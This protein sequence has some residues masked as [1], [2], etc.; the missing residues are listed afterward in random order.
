VLSL[1]NHPV[2]VLVVVALAA[3]LAGAT[4]EVKTS[5]KGKSHVKPRP[6]VKKAGKKAAASARAWVRTQS[7]RMARATGRGV[8]AGW[9]ATRGAA[10]RS[11]GRAAAAATKRNHP[12][13]AK[14]LRAVGAV[15]GWRLKPTDTAG[16]IAG[17]ATKPTT[18]KTSR[19][20]GEPTPAAPAGPG[21]AAGASPTTTGGT[22][23][24]EETMRIVGAARGL[25]EADP[26]TAGELDSQLVNLARAMTVLADS[27]LSYTETL[28]SIT[29]LDPRVTRHLRDAASQV[30]EVTAP[31]NRAR[32]AFRSLYSAQLDHGVRHIRKPEFFKAG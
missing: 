29:H 21:G 19:P 32:V 22:A 2:P 3:L 25:A 8:L 20:V 12:W 24:A 1:L 9:N 15:T 23:M 27:I 13:V 31:F 26:D 11:A 6:W 4:V 5:K 30:A 14:G 28:E 10:A 18:K 7:G 16:D 17:E